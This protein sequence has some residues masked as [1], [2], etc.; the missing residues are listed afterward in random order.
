MAVFK[1]SVVLSTLTQTEDEKFTKGKGEA[2]S[3]TAQSAIRRCN[4]QQCS[5]VSGWLHGVLMAQWPPVQ[6]SS[7]FLEM[8]GEQKK[9]ISAFQ[10]TTTKC[11][12]S[13][14]VS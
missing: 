12:I 3:H 2:G 14:C 9:S 13:Q 4:A 1:R 7:S 8:Q 6:G 10:R 11:K 5:W